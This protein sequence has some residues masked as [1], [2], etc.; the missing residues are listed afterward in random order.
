MTCH[1]LVAVTRFE[2]MHARVGEQIVDIAVPLILEKI[3]EMIQLVPLERIKDQI[4]ERIV[5]V[6]VPQIKEDIVEVTQPVLQERVQNR[7]GRQIGG[8]ASAPDQGDFLVHG[9]PV[10]PPERVQNRSCNQFV[11]VP[12]PQI[13]AK[14]WDFVQPVPLER[15]HE[16]TWSRFLW[17]PRPRRKSCL[18]FCACHRSVSE[19]DS[20][21]TFLWCPSPRKLSK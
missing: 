11:D 2:R 9:V 7:V 15:T 8:R 14:L 18:L 4:V 1:Q 17:C 13:T 5:A 19:N 12:V 10:V 6:L 20:W 21:K 3:A 16:R